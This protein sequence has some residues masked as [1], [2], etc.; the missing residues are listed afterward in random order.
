MATW[1]GQLRVHLILKHVLPLPRLSHNTTTL[2]PLISFLQE[3]RGFATSTRNNHFFFFFCKALTVLPRNL[4]ASISVPRYIILRH[5]H[6][7]NSLIFIHM[8]V[9]Y[10]PL[11]S[12]F[13]KNQTFL[14]YNLRLSTSYLTILLLL[15]PMQAIKIEW[16][17]WNPLFRE[18][19]ETP[20]SLTERGRFARCFFWGGKT[21]LNEVI[22]EYRLN[23][24]FEYKNAFFPL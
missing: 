13:G 17:C 20:L 5:R 12:F 3:T 4:H 18:N 23:V 14:C 8:N 19:K 10:L 11:K 16:N 22:I 21:I 2:I 7:S 15:T 1:H 9:I 6:S 24:R